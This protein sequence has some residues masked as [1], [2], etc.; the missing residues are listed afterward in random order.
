MATGTWLT[1]QTHSRRMVL[2]TLKRWENGFVIRRGT[3][4][5]AADNVDQHIIRGVWRER[6]GG[7]QIVIA[8]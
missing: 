6:L 2:G 5:F 4:Q 8:S 7:E 3:I 1:T